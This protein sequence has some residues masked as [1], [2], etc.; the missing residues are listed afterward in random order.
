M[1]LSASPRL[2]RQVG[3]V[4]EQLDRLLAVN[5]GLLEKCR[6]E[7]PDTTEIAAL[8][9]VLHSF[10]TGIENLFKRVA[11]ETAGSMPCGES[12]HADLLESMRQ[13]TAARPALIDDALRARLKTYLDFRHVFR[14]AYTFELNWS[15]MAPLVLDMHETLRLLKIAV[16]AFFL[17]LEQE[18]G[19]ASPPP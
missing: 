4:L 6:T 1:S 12:W 15:R 18:L 2:A 3:V 19:G 14:H 16:N 11:V 9:A 17:S 13:S 7:S 5:G 8:S 10:Y